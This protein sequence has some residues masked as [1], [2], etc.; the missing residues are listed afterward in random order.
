M[1]YLTLKWL[2]VMFS[3]V[4]FG[5]GIGSAFY[6]LLASVRREPVALAAATRHVVIADWLFTAPTVVL[7]PMTGYALAHAAGLPLA[8]PWLMWA[9]VLYAVAIACWL[10]VVFIQ[11]RLREYAARAVHCGTLER[12]YWRLFKAWVVLGII[13]LIC[14]VTIFHLMVHQPSLR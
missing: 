13:A 8:T 9:G 1:E 3:T 2:H 5:T 11:I 6:L 7:Q 10:P 12:G 14:F 4:L